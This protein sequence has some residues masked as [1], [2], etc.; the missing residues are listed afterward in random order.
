MVDSLGCKLSTS[1]HRA[2]G[3]QPG[4]AYRDDHHNHQI[5]GGEEAYASCL[6]CVVLCGLTK[7]NV[8]RDD[9]IQDHI[10]SAQINGWPLQAML[11]GK[12]S[13]LYQL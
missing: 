12:M 2:A 9:K 4:L 3:E 1:S 10:N 6:C 7:K 5:G 8:D 13:S 11:H